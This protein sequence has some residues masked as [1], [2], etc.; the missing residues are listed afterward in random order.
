MLIRRKSRGLNI[1][2]HS[3]QPDA[4]GNASHSSSTS[5]FLPPLVVT[6]HRTVD[7]WSW[8]APFFF[9]PLTVAESSMFC[10]PTSKSAVTIV[11]KPTTGRAMKRQGRANS[12]RA[13]RGPRTK[14]STATRTAKKEL[15]PMAQP[16][17]VDRTS[18]RLGGLRPGMSSTAKYADHWSN[19]PGTRYTE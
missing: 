14:S 18:G 1:A 11:L 2:T 4:T 8:S 5:N 15:C 7:V 16:P 13:K 10:P 9:F 19:L 3:R 17:S 12:C 6:L